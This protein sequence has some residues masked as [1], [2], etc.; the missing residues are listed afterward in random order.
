MK[1][2]E[3][4]KDAYYEQQARFTESNGILAQ[5]RDE[6]RRALSETAQDRDEWKEAAAQA[7]AAIEHYQGERNKSDAYAGQLAALLREWH[8]H[9]NLP[10]R[11]DIRERTEALLQMSGG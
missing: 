5:E 4:W 2:L 3:D 8:G 7:N 6:A 10:L 1:T 9:I 11:S